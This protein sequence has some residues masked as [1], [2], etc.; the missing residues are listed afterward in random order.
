MINYKKSDRYQKVDWIRRRRGKQYK[1]LGNLLSMLA[2][3]IPMNEFTKIYE[4]ICDE[5]GICKD[6]T[7]KDE[8]L[9]TKKRC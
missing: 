1:R 7:E 8:Q 4:Y 2:G 5:W 3:Q 9:K 6:Q